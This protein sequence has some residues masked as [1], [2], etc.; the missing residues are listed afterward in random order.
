MRNFLGN[1]T[2]W[3]LLGRQLRQ[4]GTNTH[5]L[6]IVFSCIRHWCHVW[7]RF[8]LCAFVCIYI[9]TWWLCGPRSSMLLPCETWHRITIFLALRTHQTV[10]SLSLDRNSRIRYEFPVLWSPLFC[11]RIFVQIKFLLKHV[12]EGLN[13]RL[14]MSEIPV[15]E[16]IGELNA[17]NGNCGFVRSQFQ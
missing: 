1:W 10:T 16:I 8:S 5:F 4:C 6:V 14:W 11:V 2:Q 9:H 12:D 7:H 15:T 17:D 3:N 13:S